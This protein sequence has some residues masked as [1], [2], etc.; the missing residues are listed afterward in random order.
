MSYY[1]PDKLPVNEGWL[2]M[3]TET[4]AWT[5][6]VPVS[7]K[8]RR[9]Q[10]MYVRVCAKFYATLSRQDYRVSRIYRVQNLDLWNKYQT[11]VTDLLLQLVKSKCISL[12][13]FFTTELRSVDF[14]INTFFIK[15]F[16]TTSIEIIQLCRSHF[17]FELPNIMLKKRSE[18]FGNKYTECYCTRSNIYRVGQKNC[19]RLSLQ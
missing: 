10:E 16:K 18:K 4:P 13:N 12:Y 1:D 5:D 8:H 15:L 6:L 3:D 2:P 14:V 9:M 11:Y 19:T 7:P 17:C